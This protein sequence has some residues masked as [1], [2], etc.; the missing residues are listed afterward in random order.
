MYIYADNIYIVASGFLKKQ[1]QSYTSMIQSIINKWTNE[2]SA[3]TPINKCQARQVSRKYKR[4][5]LPI[6]KRF[7]YPSE[8][9]NE[10]TWYHI[11][12][13]L[14]IERPHQTCC[15]QNEK[16]NNLLKITSEKPLT[17][18]LVF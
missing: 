5:W 18:K 9:E 15:R 10:N 2:V 3:T 12:K 8:R 16:A 17:W 7:L 13:N 14:S 6:S 4:N 11:F 1:V